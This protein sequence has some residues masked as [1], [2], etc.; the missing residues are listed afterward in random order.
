MCFL[1][2]LSNSPMR[3][4]ILFSFSNGKA[5]VQDGQMTFS[6]SHSPSPNLNLG[7]L[8]PEATQSSPPHSRTLRIKG[9]GTSTHER[10]SDRELWRRTLTEAVVHPSTRQRQ[11]RMKANSIQSRWRLICLFLYRNLNEVHFKI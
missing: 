2:I 1:S 6:R 10:L 4:I 7:S 11:R 3:Q 8:T 5:E 9:T